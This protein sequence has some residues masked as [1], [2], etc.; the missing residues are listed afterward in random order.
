[1]GRRS[2]RLRFRQSVTSRGRLIALVLHC[3]NDEFHLGLTLD[4]QPDL[5][6]VREMYFDSGG[7]LS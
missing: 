2:S 5:L 6:R 1:M 7:D 3:Q 4:V